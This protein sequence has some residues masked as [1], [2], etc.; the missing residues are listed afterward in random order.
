MTDDVS[1]DELAMHVERLH[2]APAKYLETV[3]VKETFQGKSRPGKLGH[4]PG[5]GAEGNESRHRLHFAERVDARADDS[6]QA[7]PKSSRLLAFRFPSPLIVPSW[8]LVFCWAHEPH[9]VAI[10]PGSGGDSN[11]IE[12]APNVSLISTQTASSAQQTWV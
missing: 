7:V 2:H 11:R 9:R 6:G 12:W 5:A 4:Y 1:T 10:S 8:A 3:E